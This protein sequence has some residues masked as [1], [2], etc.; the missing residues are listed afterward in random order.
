MEARIQRKYERAIEAV[1]AQRHRPASI[2]TGQ[3]QRRGETVEQ[4]SEKNPEPRN[5]S[6]TIA[7]TSCICRRVRTVKVTLVHL[8]EVR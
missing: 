2:F 3:T 1:Y 7:Y 5:A 4:A 8:P 6:G